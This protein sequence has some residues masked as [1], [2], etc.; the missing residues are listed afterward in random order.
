MP[1]TYCLAPLQRAIAG[2]PPDHHDPAAVQV[3]RALLEEA[4]AIGRAREEQRNYPEPSRL[5]VTAE[6]TLAK[7]TAAG[8][9]AA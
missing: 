7:L 4:C 2:A 9:Q 5:R 6:E 1:L 3:A 8:P